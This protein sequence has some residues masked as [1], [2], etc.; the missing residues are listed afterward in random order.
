MFEILFR[1]V[2]YLRGLPYS[3]LQLHLM[4]STFQTLV[5]FPIKILIKIGGIDIFIFSVLSS[6]TEGPSVRWLQHVGITPLSDQY[7]EVSGLLPYLQI[8]GLWYL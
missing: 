6:S 2:L 5:P 4:C 8:K 7:L 3:A 1:C